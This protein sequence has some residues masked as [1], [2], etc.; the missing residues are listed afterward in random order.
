MSSLV[1]VIASRPYPE[2]VSGGK[3]YYT[4]EE[5]LREYERMPEDLKPFFGYYEAEIEIM[6]ERL[7]PKVEK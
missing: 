5:A 3:F 7:F 2:K 6:P 1:Y 4:E